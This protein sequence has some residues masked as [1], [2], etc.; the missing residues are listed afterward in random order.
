MAVTQ[1]QGP[2]VVGGSN[3]A[4]NGYTPSY[5]QDVGPSP[6]TS[7][8]ALY[9]PRWQYRDASAANKAIGF[10]GTNYIPVLDIVPATATSTAI[11]TTQAPTTGTR[12]SLTA[13]TGVTSLNKASVVLPTQ[14]IIP[15]GTLVI[16]GYPATISYGN[17]GAIAEYDITSLTAR[18]VTITSYGDERNANFT[19]AG[20][21][22]WGVALTEKITGGNATTV[23]GKKAF[24]FVS[25]VTAAGTLSG[26]NVSVGTADVFGLPIRADGFPWVTA[27]WN[28]A[29]TTSLGFT[30]AVTTTATSA[31]G[32][33]RGTIAVQSASDGV[34]R[35]VVFV[36]PKPANIA[37]VAG[38]FGVT[39]A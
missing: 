32:D 26:W 5:N 10:Q 22:V 4:L 12:M 11:A 13:G 20:Y 34:K 7:G 25:S 9:D 28:N 29:L 2:L 14:T 38:L 24:K 39:Q 15:A 33:T 30:A 23:S 21:D 19:V 31:T 35:L 18:A 37:S 1:I 17:T 36:T 27:Y 6:V 3:V 16:G 8:T